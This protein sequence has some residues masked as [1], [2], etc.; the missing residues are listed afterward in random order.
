LFFL[1]LAVSFNQPKFCSTPAWN[2]DAT[3]FANQSIIGSSPGTL[4]IDA[5]DSVYIV[6]QK[7][8]QILVW[9]DNN[10]NQPKAIS[11]NFSNSSSIFVT[12]NGDVYIDN[13]QSNGRVEK[14]I[15]STHTFVTVMNVY[16]SCYGLFVGSNDN[17]YCSMSNHHQ[18]AKSTLHDRRITSATVAGTGTKGSA[19]NE[20][21][22]PHGIFV[23]AKFDLYVADCGNDRVQL[24]RSGE[25]DGITFVG[26]ESASPTI[27]LDCPT[28]ITF[29]AQKYL[30]IVDSNNHRVVRS[31]INGIQCLV[32]CHGSGSQSTQLSF[33]SSL[34]FDHSGNMFVVDQKNSRIQK[35][36]Y[37]QNSCGK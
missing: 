24:F 31:G 18:V 32:G 16:S 26:R 37:S 8:N 35:F 3:T 33:P 25:L 5:K 21:D 20:L 19:S 1:F 10:I 34:S 22:H 14:L 15:S 30:F 23:D 17:L 11:G 4:F 9:N 36:H 13:G 2:R 27:S 12:S 6:N 7:T 29:D 28:G